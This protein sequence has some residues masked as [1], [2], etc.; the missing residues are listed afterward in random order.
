MSVII[1]I[2]LGLAIMSIFSGVSTLGGPTSQELRARWIGFHNRPQLIVKAVELMFNHLKHMSSIDE[3]IEIVRESR[4]PDVLW[5]INYITPSPHMEKV[6]DLI[7]RS[8]LILFEEENPLVL[9]SQ[10]TA[11]PRNMTILYTIM[12]YIK[13]EDGQIEESL[14]VWDYAYYNCLYNANTTRR[15]TLLTHLSTAYLCSNNFDK[16]LECFKKHWALLRSAT[17]KMRY[18][19]GIWDDMTCLNIVYYFFARHV[20]RFSAF[21]AKQLGI[22][23]EC[24]RPGKKFFISEF[25]DMQF[26]VQMCSKPYYDHAKLSMPELPDYDLS[27]FTTTEKQKE[28]H[29]QHIPDE[30]NMYE[31]NY[32]KCVHSQ[33]CLP[34]F[35]KESVVWDMWNSCHWDPPRQPA[36][37]DEDDEYQ[38]DQIEWIIGE[39]V[40]YDMDKGSELLLKFIDSNNQTYDSALDLCCGTSRVMYDHFLHQKLTQ[41]D[42]STY[43]YNYCKDQGRTIIKQPAEIFLDE[44]EEHFDLC[45]CCLSLSYLT[46]LDAILLS[47]SKK[48][49]YFAAS[50]VHGAQ[51]FPFSVGGIDLNKTTQRKEWWEKQVS[52][53]FDIE[54][55]EDE[56]ED[57]ISNVFNVF[58]KSK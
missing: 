8:E 23:E 52:K 55:M 1:G 5:N 26:I 19:C 21:W 28:I 58:C 2:L 38:E 18:R 24:L 10:Y 43:V 36:A 9:K 35:E 29:R 6:N 40:E 30:L 14:A 15:T 47:I 44:T 16:S 20:P 31:E 45:I 54:K 3:W 50:I 27:M 4:H 57:N 39:D 34:A 51:I 33:E 11:S 12:A 22:G 48:C 46:S 53:Y 41:V 13:A 7:R 17:E 49:K 32:M 37:R 42:I 25:T 56:D